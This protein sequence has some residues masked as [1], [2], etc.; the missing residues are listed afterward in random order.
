MKSQT[1]ILKTIEMDSERIEVLK[2]IREE[3]K[4]LIEEPDK[5]Q[6]RKVEI[7]EYEDGSYALIGYAWDLPLLKEEVPEAV[8]S[9]INGDLERGSRLNERNKTWR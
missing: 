1:D 4:K 7:K 5:I 6:K 8:E 3:R 2:K 9:W